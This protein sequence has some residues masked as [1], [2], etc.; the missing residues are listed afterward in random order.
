MGQPKECVATSPS[1][2]P[3]TDLPELLDIDGNSFQECSPVLI[4][5]VFTVIPE[6]PGPVMLTDVH[7][8]K[9]NVQG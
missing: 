7:V 3:T 6:S 9:P 4:P 5:G 2:A 8:E 1:A